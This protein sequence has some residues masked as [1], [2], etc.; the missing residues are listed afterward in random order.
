VATSAWLGEG[1]RVRWLREGVRVRQPTHAARAQ[2]DLGQRWC[3]AAT[4]QGGELRCMGRWSA[5]SM[6]SGGTRDE[7]GRR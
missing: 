2:V 3:L 6:A 7:G 1:V 5:T 4:A